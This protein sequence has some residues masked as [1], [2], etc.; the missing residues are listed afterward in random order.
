PADATSVRSP[1]P[2]GMAM[3]RHRRVGCRPHAGSRAE[4]TCARRWP[5]SSEDASSLVTDAVRVARIPTCPATVI[6]TR[7]AV[8]VEWQDQVKSRPGTLT[9]NRL[10]SAGLRVSRFVV[11]EV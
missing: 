10:H 4:R 5:A 9:D 8:P 1:R 7:L 2:A 6:A 3:Q 11:R